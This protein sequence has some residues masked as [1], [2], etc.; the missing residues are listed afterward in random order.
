MK[1]GERGFTS[2]LRVNRGLQEHGFATALA[3][4]GILAFATVV[5]GLAAALALA[6][7]FALAVVLAHVTTGRIGAG[8]IGAGVLCLGDD[9]GQQ[10]GDG[11]GDEEGSLCSIHNV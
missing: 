8:R 2:A 10:P 3:F 4:A 7:V 5:T 1:V 9:A 11:R 6:T